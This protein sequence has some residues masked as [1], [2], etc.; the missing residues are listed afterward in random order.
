M[1]VATLLF[2]LSII[3]VC[4]YF[5]SAM[6]Y[7]AQI[8]TVAISSLLI[9]ACWHKYNTWFAEFHG[10]NIEFWQTQGSMPLNRNELKLIRSMGVEAAGEKL[11]YPI[12]L[13]IASIKA[14]NGKPC[15]EKATYDDGYEDEYNW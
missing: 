1:A 14:C 5:F 12:D 10:K 13:L 3:I 15:D 9:Y 11:G 7:N 6:S 4:V 8:L 2:I